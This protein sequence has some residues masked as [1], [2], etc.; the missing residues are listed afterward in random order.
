VVCIDLFSPLAQHTYKVILAPLSQPY[1]YLAH[2]LFFFSISNSNLSL[3]LIHYPRSRQSLTESHAEQ[4][5]ASA[6]QA[7]NVHSGEVKG[8]ASELSGKASELSGEAKGKANE[9]AGEAKGKKEELKGEAK[10][11]LS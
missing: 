9:V 5:A 10:S 2:L 11:K 6:K 7:A 8:K 1:L 4:A 3:L